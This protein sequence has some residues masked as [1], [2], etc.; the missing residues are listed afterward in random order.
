ML[1]RS[2]LIA[3][4]TAAV[5]ALTAC[6]GD[7][8][9][10]QYRSGSNKGYIAGD[11][12]IETFSE[13]SRT[14]PEEFTAETDTGNRISSTELTGDVL[15]LNFWYASCPPCRAE[16]RDLE[17]LNR[18]FSSDGVRFLGVNTRDEAS[19]AQAFAQTFGLTY[20]SILDYRTAEVQ[21]ALSDAVP[22]NAVPTT[23]VFDREGRVAARIL[24]QVTEPST[25]EAIIEDTLSEGSVP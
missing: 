9:A 17:A 3:A 12:A 5:L 13:D 21:L 11:G 2:A 7:P 20:P 14:A 18:R 23:L 25:L 22:P 24:G 6:G 4:V 1:R 10:E 15:V 8:L 16:A 19:T